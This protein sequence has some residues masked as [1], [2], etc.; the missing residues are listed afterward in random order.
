M[1]A[2]TLTNL[3]LEIIKLYATDLERQDLLDLK[4]QL[5]MFFAQKAINGVDKVWDDKKLTNADMDA[6]LNEE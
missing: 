4:Q 1:Y 6:W 3:Q 2:P 5:A